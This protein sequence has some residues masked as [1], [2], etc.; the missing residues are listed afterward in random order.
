MDKPYR[1]KSQVDYNPELFPTYE[2]IRRS[3]IKEILK[4]VSVSED[5]QKKFFTNKRY[6][7]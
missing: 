1:P 2:S 4:P 6:R 5:Q 3:D 7:K